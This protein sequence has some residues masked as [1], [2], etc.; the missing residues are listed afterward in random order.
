MPVGSF[1]RRVLLVQGRDTFAFRN[2]LILTLFLWAGQ[3][4]AFHGIWLP[5]FGADQA[6]LAGA[7][8][9][10]FGSPLVLEENPALLSRVKG[11]AFQGQIALN[12][13][14]VHYEDE[15]LDPKLGTYYRNDRD[16][17]PIA[18]LPAMGYSYGGNRWAWGLALYAQG[19]G[20]ADFPGLMRAYPATEV[21]T[22]GAS[23][24][25]V[26]NR[27]G[28]AKET[29]HAQ[30][31][32]IKATPGLSY[33]W[34]AF[35]LGMAADLIY[36]TKRMDRSYSDPL[37]G[38]TLPGGFHYQSDPA[39]ALGAKIGAS[40]DTDHWSF[41]ASFT[42][43]SRFYLDGRI[44]T[45]TYDPDYAYPAHVSRFMEWPARFVAGLEYRTENYRFVA[46]ISHTLW[47]ASMNSLLFTLDRPLI[48]AP[49]GFRS[50]Y[51]RMNLRWRD[52]TVVS[53]GVERSLED[54]RLRAGYSYGRTPQTAEGVNPLLGTTVEHMV[55]LGLGWLFD[56]GSQEVYPD[57]QPSSFD[58]AL[59]YCFP[60]TVKGIP[61]SEWWL[62]HAVAV[63]PF[64]VSLLSFEKETQV[65]TLYLGFT[66][67]WN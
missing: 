7:F 50:P 56:G 41:A 11:H 67:R 15:Y 65:I 47:S 4:H 12:Q 63:E 49:L 6:G 38:A 66:L 17:R 57:S 53:L 29:I 35:S 30:F 28:L 32:L 46:D 3:A 43:A 10:P 26:T 23:G 39:Y 21:R 62:G 2:L 48:I 34:G 9:S 33:D 14:R 16:F 64:Q 61:F 18:P 42:S 58:I 25:P 13:A 37:T 51:L 24:A 27:S 5:S 31:A 59:Q 54:I 40:Y 19:G 36:A 22:D 20:G 45:D 8:Y 1:I 60:H 52:Q 44:R 55:T